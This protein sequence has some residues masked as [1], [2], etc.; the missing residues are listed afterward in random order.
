M[1]NK[2]NLE[3]EVYEKPTLE[4][5]LLYMPVE[6]PLNPIDNNYLY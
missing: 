4:L 3:T 1:I 2:W 6:D 5:N